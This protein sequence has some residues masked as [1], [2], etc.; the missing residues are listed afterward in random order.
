M[1]E[2]LRAEPSRGGWVEMTVRECRTQ[3]AGQPY[4]LGK[5]HHGDVV[6]C[7]LSQLL[8][9]TQHGLQIQLGEDNCQDRPGGGCRREKDTRALVLSPLLHVTPI[10]SSSRPLQ[11]VLEFRSP[12]GKRKGAVTRGE[13]YGFSGMP[14]MLPFLP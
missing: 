14:I 1:R 8:Y 9:L 5:C 7:L 12:L 10:L 4:V 2:R 3:K 6:T 13:Q 11:S